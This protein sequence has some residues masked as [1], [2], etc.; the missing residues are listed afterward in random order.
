MNEWTD[1]WYA[2]ELNESNNYLLKIIEEI[3]VFLP[4]P[5]SPR[6]SPEDKEK[7]KKLLK[8][9]K[10]SNNYLLEIIDEIRVFLP[11]LSPEYSY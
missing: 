7:K 10:E 2:V 8:E 1:L 11:Q 6:L 3:R 5:E 4:L 9:L